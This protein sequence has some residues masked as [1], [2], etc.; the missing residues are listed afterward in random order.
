[1]QAVARLADWDDTFVSTI[2]T[3]STKP[4]RRAGAAPAPRLEEVKAPGKNVKD[5]IDVR[6]AISCN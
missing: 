6:Y 2:T 3:Q 1:M 4:G 5:Q